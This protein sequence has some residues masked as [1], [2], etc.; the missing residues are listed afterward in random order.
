[1]I[2]IGL[3]GSIATG[4]TFV[5]KC[6]AKLGAKVFDADE[7]VHQLLTYSGKA[8]KPVREAFPES[9]DEGCIC[10][11]KLGK[12]VFGDNDKRQ[13]LESI[14]HPL[15]AKEREKFLDDARKRK[16]SVVVL[17]IPLLFESRIKTACD[18]VVVTIVDPKIQKERALEREGMTSQRFDA[19]NALQMDSAEKARRANFVIDTKNSEF[20]VFRKVKEI[21]HDVRSKDAGDSI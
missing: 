21:M 4:K 6:F 5:A 17:E 2:I 20:S 7:V 13:R 14:M 18:Y 8:V 1:M 11:K 15:V 16:I 9:Y 3:T 10:R 19:I 12:I